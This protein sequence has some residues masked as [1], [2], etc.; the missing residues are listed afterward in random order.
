MYACLSLTSRGYFVTNYWNAQSWD[1][2]CQIKNLLTS[3][4]DYTIPK[5]YQYGDKVLL[6]LPA[7][8]MVCFMVISYLFLTRIILWILIDITGMC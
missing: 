4:G 3:L 2:V 1:C 6:F 8:C 7:E 5:N